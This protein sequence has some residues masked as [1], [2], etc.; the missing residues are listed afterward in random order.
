MFWGK[1]QRRLLCRGEIFFANRRIIAKVAWSLCRG[2][3]GKYVATEVGRPLAGSRGGIA[4]IAVDEA[5]AVLGVEKPADGTEGTH[6][7]YRKRYAA[8][9]QEPH[10]GEQIV[11]AVESESELDDI[12]P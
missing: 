9:A 8:G 7:H 5:G 3:G 11:P 1:G 4:Q 2:E 10:A 12:S 6:A